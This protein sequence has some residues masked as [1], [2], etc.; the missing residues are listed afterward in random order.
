[1]D[2]ELRFMDIHLQMRIGIVDHAAH[3]LAQLDGGH[4]E[5]LVRP[6]GLHLEGFGRHEL[7]MEIGGRRL[8]EGI[9][10]LLAGLGAA[11]ARHAEHRLN[12]RPGALQIAG[13]LQRL[14][15]HR[16]LPGIDAEAAI[17]VDAAAD[18]GGQP[19]LELA[20]VQPLQDD[21]AH[22]EQKDLSA[23]IRGRFFLVCHRVS[24][25]Y[26]YYFRI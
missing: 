17:L 21:L 19:I 16:G 5:A 6:L 14:H 20:A 26:T 11:Q 12:G 8:K 23:L 4:G 24:S 1:M 15:I 18:I 22:L 9:L 25:R 13:C 3:I 10:V 7:V 2:G